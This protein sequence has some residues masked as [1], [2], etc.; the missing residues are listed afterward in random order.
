ML[1]YRHKKKC[2]TTSRF[3]TLWLGHHFLSHWFFWLSVCSILQKEGRKETVIHRNF[4]LRRPILKIRVPKQVPRRRE[5]F[6]YFGQI[7]IGPDL[8]PIF[9]KNWHFLDTIA[10]SHIFVTMVFLTFKQALKRAKMGK[11]FTDYLT[12]ATLSSA[13]KC[14]LASLRSAWDNYYWNIGKFENFASL[15]N[16]QFLTI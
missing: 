10:W 15:K 16:W 3:T 5:T 13:H 2:V 7:S 9:A 1:L 12:F 8:D 4:W 14:G 6:L 11:I